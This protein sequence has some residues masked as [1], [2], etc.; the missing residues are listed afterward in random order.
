MKLSR[1]LP[2]D[3]RGLILLFV[4]LSV[5]ATLC[6]SLYVA[7]RVQRD[8]LIHATLEANGAYAAKVAS[9]IG[10]F[11]GAAH[12]HL[13]YSATV[14]GDHWD[15]PGA[16]RKEAMRLQA[17][18]T[19][20]NSV[21][22][23]DANGQVLQAYPDSLQIVGATLQSQGIQQALKERRPL[24][25]EVYVSSAGN[26]VVFVSQP[27]FS[28]SGVFLGVVG[29]SVYL[30]EQSAFHT[31]ISRHFHHDGT[32]AFVADGN[33]RLLYHPDSKRI[34]E[35][36]GWSLTVDAALRGE[37]GTLQGDNYRGVPMLAGY[38]RVPE[39]NWAV[40][41]QQPRER[42]LAPLAQ[43][44][45]DMVVGMIPAGLLGLAL[46]LA[47]TALIARPLRQLSAAADQLAAPDTTERLNRV[48]A[49]Y[50][51]AAA[52]RQAMLAGVQLLH[53]KLGQL[54]HEAQSDPLTGL[55]NRRA[56]DAALN[57]LDQS[58]QGYSV[59]A[60]DIDHFKRV[61]DTFGHDAGDVALRSVADILKQNLRSGD[62]ACRSGG[63]EFALILPDTPLDTARMIAERVRAHLEETEVPQVG[64][65]TMSIG[66]ACRD[67]DIATSP[68]VLKLADER[69]YIAKQSGRNK[70]V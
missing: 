25:S 70:V 66:V 46:I 38:A 21:T 7:Y 48:H 63:E 62:W 8:A 10:E 29:G 16:L 44:M 54:S 53:Q 39:A 47:G 1:P 37:S 34:G 23:L 2:I 9:S 67:A 49:W 26:L 11:L 18:D 13:S 15:E 55:A 35:V 50:R 64:K 14:L 45:R 32:F 58:G 43:L 51:D 69:L 30:L 60:L 31:V 24:V 40:V 28:P 41:V 22:I 6:N 56:M 3:L 12:N 68:S 61:N 42:S 36:L 65:L 20:F 52:I 17:Q 27:V 4:L 19:D 33:R 57:L 5:V 59:L